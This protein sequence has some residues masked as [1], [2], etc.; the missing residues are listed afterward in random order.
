MRNTE[1]LKYCGAGTG[2]GMQDQLHCMH[3]PVHVVLHRDQQNTAVCRAGEYPSP[4][5]TVPLITGP[6]MPPCSETNIT[7]RYAEQRVPV[8]L[9]YHALSY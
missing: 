5:V 3:Q 6:R 9:G 4:L 1:K 8:A 2:R 7:L